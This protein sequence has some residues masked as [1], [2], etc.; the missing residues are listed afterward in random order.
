M[1]KLEQIIADIKKLE[2]ELFVELQKKQDEYFTSSR[3]KKY[4]SKRK[5]A[6]TTKH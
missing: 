5:L 3:V 4:S 2:Q 6:N 1:N